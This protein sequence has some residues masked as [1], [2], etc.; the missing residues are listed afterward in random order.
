MNMSC[1]IFG[2]F[3]DDCDIFSDYSTELLISY[4][5]KKKF[6]PVI[7][8]KNQLGNILLSCNLK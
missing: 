6:K 1:W 2:V 8:A 5:G 4:C 7:Q 3:A